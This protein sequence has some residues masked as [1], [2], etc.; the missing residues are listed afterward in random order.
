MI[1]GMGRSPGGGNGSLR[2]LRGETLTPAFLLL[3]PVLLQGRGQKC[4][5]SR[6]WEGRSN[7]VE[8]LDPTA[9]EVEVSLG[10]SC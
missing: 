4:R 1:P 2:I 6:F 3:L 5:L 8:Y 7:D 10:L 9:K